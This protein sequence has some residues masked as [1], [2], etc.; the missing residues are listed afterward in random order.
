MANTNGIQALFGG[1]GSGSEENKS[2]DITD[3]LEKKVHALKKITGKKSFD[4]WEII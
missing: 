4:L 2:N 1:G 3:A